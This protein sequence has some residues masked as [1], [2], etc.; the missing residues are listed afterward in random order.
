MDFFVHDECG[1]V[2]MAG[3]CPDD[4]LHLQQAPP[5]LTLRR[6]SAVVGVH[7][8]SRARGLVTRPERPSDGH[9]FDYGAGRWVLDEHKAW[10]LVRARRDS[11]LASTDWRVIK[12]QEAGQSLAPEWGVYR[13]ALRDVTAQANPGAIDWP[14]PPS[15]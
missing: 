15:E 12:A 14:V 2:L 3:T 1:E 4:Q 8:W 5:G 7:Y 10:A 11:L 6:G 13:Q 9:N